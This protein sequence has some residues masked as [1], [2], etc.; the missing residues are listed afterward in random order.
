LNEI[1]C[2]NAGLAIQRCKQEA[3]ERGERE[4]QSAIARRMFSLME[5]DDG[6]PARTLR[7]LMAG[8][9]RWAPEYIEA[10]AA[11]TQ[12]P[13]ERLVSTSYQGGKIPEAEYGAFLARITGRR[14]TPG[15]V[16]TLADNI[17]REL[18]QPG[19][20][21]LVSSISLAL[22]TAK[23]LREARDIVDELLRENDIWSDQASKKRKRR[24][25]TK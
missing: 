9:P 13:P 3:R 2:K 7:G 24:K 5:K 10:F 15:Q 17:R 12:T 8:K 25:A 1:I 4:S 23:E 14:L 11:A 21:A 22:S 6:D 16:K 19:L 20:F 18:E